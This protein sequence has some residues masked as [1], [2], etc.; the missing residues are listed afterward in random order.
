MILPWLHSYDSNFHPF[1]LLFHKPDRKPSC[2]TH[3]PVLKRMWNGEQWITAR[4]NG[5]CPP[6][7]MHKLSTEAFRFHGSAEVLWK[8]Q[9]ELYRRAT[10]LLKNLAATE[11]SLINASN[12]AITCFIPASLS[13]CRHLN[14]ENAE[15]TCVR[16][17]RFCSSS[18]STSLF[19]TG[20][21][22][23]LFHLVFDISIVLFWLHLGLYTSSKMCLMSTGLQDGNL[24]KLFVLHFKTG[25]NGTPYGILSD[26]Y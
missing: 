18:G 11:P 13:D 26:L 19:L 5:K 12:C 22:N 9:Q 14:Q 23:C 2:L 21:D 3:V 10:F 20:L 17:F 6:W 7:L 24:M 16:M 4:C 15:R 25:L 8:R 1:G